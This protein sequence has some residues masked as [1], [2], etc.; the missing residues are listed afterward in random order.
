MLTEAQF[1]GGSN[2]ITGITATLTMAS[3]RV[4]VYKGGLPCQITLPDPRN[5]TLE[6]RDLGGPR[7]IVITTA[8]SASIIEPVSSSTI[9]TI[10]AG[11]V[12]QIDLVDGDTPKW[13]VRTF[14]LGTPRTFSRP[15]RDPVVSAAE[16]TTF[17]PDCFYGE[18]C[19]L[20]DPDPLDGGDGR[21]LVV[22][23]MVH[24][25]TQFA[26]NYWREPIRVADVCMPNKLS[27]TI[28][29]GE[30]VKD[31]LHPNAG[32]TLSDEFWRKFE[33][34]GYAHVLEYATQADGTSRNP[35][36][37]RGKTTASFAWDHGSG[38]ALTVTR[39]IW[40]KEVQYDVD[41]STYTLRLWFVAE[42]TVADEPDLWPGETAT[43]TS[44]YI[45]QWPPTNGNYLQ[46]ALPPFGTVP[47]SWEAYG[48]KAGMR[49]NISGFTGGGYNGEAY[50][51]RIDYDK[52]YI[53]GATM[54]FDEDG[55]SVTVS[56]VAGGAQDADDGIWGTLFMVYAFTDEL[57][58]SFSEGN[59]HQPTGFGSAYAFTREDP[60]ISGIANGV[61]ESAG[62][63]GCHP[64]ML[65]GAAVV[66]TWHDPLLAE[67]IPLQF[68]KYQ[69]SGG[70]AQVA[71]INREYEYE[72]PNCSPWVTDP[73]R[74]RD[75]CE[76]CFAGGG[77]SAKG[78]HRTV[79]F[80][81]TVGGLNAAAMTLGG[82]CPI[83]YIDE[84]LCLE[85]GEAIG[86]T[87][88]VPEKA[89]WDEEVGRRNTETPSASLALCIPTEWSRFETS[90]CDGHPEEPFESVGGSHRCFRNAT[91]GTAT[92]CC[93]TTYLDADPLYASQGS[94]L[95]TTA[96][97]RDGCTKTITEFGPYIGGAFCDT[98]ISQECVFVSTIVTQ[99]TLFLESYDY[100]HGGDQN[101]RDI[102]YSRYVPHP[103]QD[104]RHYSYDQSDTGDF[105]Q[106]VGTWSYGAAAITMSIGSGGE[107][108][109]GVVL[110]QQ[111]GYTY[112]DLTVS[113]STDDAQSTAQALVAR[114]TVDGADDATG[115][116][117]VVIPDAGGDT[118]EIWKLTA[119][120]KT[121]LASKAITL[122]S[123]IVNM[124]F[125]VWGN[126]LVFSWDVNG[127]NADSLTAYDCS[128]VDGG[129]PGVANA[130]NNPDAGFT[131]F[132]VLD[133][134]TVFVVITARLAKSAAEIDFPLTARNSYGKCGETFNPDCGDCCD[135]PN[136]DCTTWTEGLTL[137]AS[138]SWAGPGDVGDTTDPTYCGGPNAYDCEGGF[139][140]S[141]CPKC[142]DCPPETPALEW[143]I[144]SRCL[145]DGDTEP[146]I[147]SG[148]RKW[149]WT[150]CVPDSPG[151]SPS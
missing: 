126:E 66:T 91:D 58:P 95:T 53:S 75:F 17:D 9:A 84:H 78:V 64:H 6:P 49:I 26:N 61:A 44:N 70:G 3:D 12:A 2:R 138:T 128:I 59:T 33:N 133:Q 4:Q 111:A 32:V 46:I 43:V 73:D 1:H 147:C 150:V 50:V 14:T 7:F 116:V 125:R 72:R 140:G 74:D 82:D 124:V 60:F 88:L 56:R 67:H 103:D 104:L 119:G 21:A 71:G 20:A 65:F 34:S 38:A 144:G 83:S 113:A 80:G 31:P 149:T 109:P 98:I 22:V 11:K 23:P 37:L 13:V 10:T 87:Y 143:C 118:A 47:T 42:H 108:L 27:L 141:S 28:A 146:N 102:D 16:P 130:E 35:Y 115:Y 107:T 18:P 68:R 134:S 55:E 127:D 110:Y 129:W 76:G 79:I 148:I 123:A 94:T 30:W 96:T 19:E 114:M 63:K 120:V 45:T 99:R 142:T 52:L 86:R 106:E 90:C 29:P 8:A 145:D 122:D 136:C 62:D 39:H 92:R 24:D 81:T 105:V 85:N 100:V 132:T 40:K 89:G 151:D 15:S 5:H 48:F 57:D 139:V 135:P 117:A 36:H 97:A 131:D 51:D 93:I 25:V 54:V 112:R 101:N 41:D 69:R 77:T 137:V 121:V